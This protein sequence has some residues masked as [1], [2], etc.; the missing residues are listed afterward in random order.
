MTSLRRASNGDWF[1]RKRIPADVRDAYEATYH[2]REEVRFRLPAET[3]SETARQEF[4]DWDATI[5]S[6]IGSLRAVARGEGEAYL[7]PR[8]TVELAGKWYV[9]FVA[10]HEEDPGSSEQWEVMADEYEAVCLRFEP[11]DEHTSTLELLHFIERPRGPAARRAVHRTVSALGN[12]ERFLHEIRRPL[13]STA[14]ATLLDA[15]EGEFLDALSLLRRRAEGDW[16]RDSHADTFAAATSSSPAGSI[17]R[18]S[19]LTVWTAFELLG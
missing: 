5:T 3:P 11:Q 18:L 8:Q 17:V 16:R 15:I 13:A 14:L 1:S 7:T 12:V 9:W 6:R 19:G 4:R 2:V 10:Q